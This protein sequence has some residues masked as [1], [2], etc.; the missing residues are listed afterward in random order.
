M[1]K[2]QEQ[3]LQ[4]C[5]DLGEAQ[6]QWENADVLGQS[7]IPAGAKISAAKSLIDEL[8]WDYFQECN[9]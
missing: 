2:S 7:T 8:A 1:T 4:A 9:E 3:L 5:Y 6:I